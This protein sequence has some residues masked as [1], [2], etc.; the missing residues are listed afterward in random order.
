MINDNVFI[1]GTCEV[2]T[3]KECDLK[4]YGEVKIGFKRIATGMGTLPP[5]KYIGRVTL[6]SA[7]RVTMALRSP[8]DTVSCIDMA[9]TKWGE[10]ATG[11]EGQ[12]TSPVGVRCTEEDLLQTVK[13]FTWMVCWGKGYRYPTK[14]IPGIGEVAHD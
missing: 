8:S 12:A 9:R 11:D 7:G 3:F 2:H 4:A 6:D 10:E 13:W 14:P 5:T 1:V